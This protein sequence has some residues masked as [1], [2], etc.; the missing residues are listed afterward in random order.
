MKFEG[1]YKN[2]KLIS[3]KCWWE[4]G[5]ETECDNVY[6]DWGDD[7]HFFQNVEKN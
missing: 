4:D 2:G 5:K 7:D 1:I 3:S 6:D